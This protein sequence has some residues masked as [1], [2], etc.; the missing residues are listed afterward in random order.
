MKKLLMLAL[1]LLCTACSALPAEERSFAVVLAMER[2]DDVWRMSARIPT[3]QTGGGYITL[4]AEGNSLAEAMAMLDASSP[5][6]LHLGQLR[7]M[8][9]SEALASSE[10]FATVLSVLAQRH[11]FRQQALL[12]VT[13]DGTQALMQQLEPVTGSRLSKSLDV[14]IETRREQGVIPPSTMAEILRMGERQSA[15]LTCV[16]LEHPEQ[17]NQPGLDQMAGAQAASGAGKVQMGGG[18]MLD[19][20]QTVRGELTAAEMQLLS[21]MAGQLR[22]GTLALHEDT[23]TLLDASAGLTLQNGVAQCKLF[24]RY[25]GSSMTEEGVTQSLS[26]AC[27]GVVSKLAAAGCDALGLGRKVMM[28]MQDMAQWHALNWPEQYAS[29]EWHIEVHA[30]RAV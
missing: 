12:C 20:G 14:M 10:N 4:T 13:R 9:F 21:L 7:M 1:A 5:M 15:L 22:K 19:A 26:Q 23:V 18:W 27:Q 30:Q 16:A 6:M 8:I 17:G 28:G 24:L 25:T 3:Y 2:S 11:D 29:L